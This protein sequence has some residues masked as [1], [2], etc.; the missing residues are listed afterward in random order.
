[1]ARKRTLLRSKLVP[2]SLNVFKSK[3]KELKTTPKLSTIL[4]FYVPQQDCEMCD[5]A[6][7]WGHGEIQ[8]D[9]KAKQLNLGPHRKAST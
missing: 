7:C 3:E 6:L 5:E 4:L 2:T 1:M 8:I 9:V